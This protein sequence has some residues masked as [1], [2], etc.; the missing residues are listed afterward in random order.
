MKKILISALCTI[1]FASQAFALVGANDLR[2]SQR[3]ITNSGNV[4]IDLPF[5]SG[6]ALIGV[7]IN[8]TFGRIDGGTGTFQVFILGSG[9]S[10]DSPTSTIT[11]AGVSQSSITG[12][13]T[14]LAGKLDMP[15]GT[16]ADYVRGDGSLATLPTAGSRAFNSPSRALNSCFQIDAA[17]D[18]DFHYKVDVT[19]ALNLTSGAQGNITA[20]SYTNSSCTTGAAIEDD[21]TSAQTGSL[22]IGLG[23]S[24]TISVPLNGTLGGGKWMKITTA[25]IIGTPTFAIRANQREIVLP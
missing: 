19:A 22:V 8:S 2:L 12:L 11:V 21:G 15:A 4:G 5:P 3:N 24:Q 23:V 14:A 20:T 10:Y 9:L 7:D 18:A 1:L 16:I 6:N 25:N 17:K 13:S